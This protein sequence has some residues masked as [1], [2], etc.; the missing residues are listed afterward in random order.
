MRSRAER[1]STISTELDNNTGKTKKIPW[2]GEDLYAEVVRIHSDM[3]MYRIENSR[4]TRQQQAYVNNHGLSKDFFKDP[5]SEE[6][7]K[8]Q[9]SILL[10]MGKSQAGFIEDL[11]ERKQQDELIITRDGYILN[12]NR[13]T[14][15]LKSLGESYFNCAVLP[16]SASAKDLYALEQEL[17]ISTDFRL[18]YDWVNELNNIREGLENPIYGFSESELAKNLR[19]S[20][21]ALKSKLKRAV[22]IDEFLNWKGIS[23]DYSNDKLDKLQQ[24]FEEL[25][26]GMKKFRENPLAL[27]K[28]K[29]QV[30]SLMD[31][32]PGIGEGRLYDHI[33]YLVKHF[34]SAQEK[35]EPQTEES[36][37]ETEN[38]NSEEG[39][40][41]DILVR[42]EEDNIDDT[43]L[44]SENSNE[45]AKKIYD[46][47]NDARAEHKD[48]QNAEA[49]FNSAKSALRE[50]T[51]LVVDEN[52]SKK[53]EAIRTLES[54]ISVANTLIGELNNE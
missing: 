54:V 2:K 48:T 4:T 44:D 22:L 28:L 3:L 25:E 46:A 17:Q 19:I 14:A 15:A 11:K 16:E 52:T 51:G 12:G 7:Q 40:I 38:V 41:I 10:E 27:E 33:R 1:L 30:F 43:L 36:S 26:K 35:L 32:P 23:G 53:E 47:I 37:G 39:D 31:N 34:D 8:A 24:A 20:P 21:Q 9:E 49:I 29:F 5:E 50:L 18:D 6:V 45:N 13:R 42:E